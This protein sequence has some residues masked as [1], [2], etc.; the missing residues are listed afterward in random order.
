[1]LYGLSLILT[2]HCPTGANAPQ[3]RGFLS[4]TSYGTEVIKNDGQCRVNPK[5][6]C[7]FVR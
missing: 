7:L 3:Y 5:E 2:V 6:Y 4:A 1:M